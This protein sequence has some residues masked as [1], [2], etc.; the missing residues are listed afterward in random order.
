M[1]TFYFLTI[2]LCF[3]VSPIVKA[4]NSDAILG[5]WFST[6]GDSKFK[7]YKKNNQYYADITWLKV[8][9][10]P[11]DGK[12]QIDRLNPNKN[13]QYRPVMGVSVLMDLVYNSNTKEWTGKTYEPRT[14]RSADCFVVLKDAKTLIITGY[15]GIRAV[16]EKETWLRIQ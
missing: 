11:I 15:I 1:K 7:L 4:Q 3:F 12:P 8:P 14:G 10:S 16:N 2:I 9:I 5:E 13:L 6:K